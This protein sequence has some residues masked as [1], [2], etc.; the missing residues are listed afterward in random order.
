MTKK[1]VSVWGA[2]FKNKTSNLFQELGS[3]IEI[4]KRLYKEDIMGSI[5][6]TSMLAKQKIIDQS[7]NK[8]N[9]SIDYLSKSKQ[10]E[11]S[12]NLFILLKNSLAF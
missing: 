9:L 7:L 1:N 4:D 2:R 3:S 6:H 8:N 12:T 5:V 11:V 10:G